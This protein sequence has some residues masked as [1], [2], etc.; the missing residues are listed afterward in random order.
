MPFFNLPPS[1]PA[2]CTGRPVAIGQWV[3]PRTGETVRFNDF[4]NCDG[5]RK[6]RRFAAILA[7]QKA[8]IRLERKTIAAILKPLETPIQKEMDRLRWN[9]PKR[10]ELR[11]KLAEIRK[12]VR[13]MAS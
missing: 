13:E 5:I 12:S 3:D 10:Q 1:S 8:A 7:E 9:D 4:G 2:K 6:V 11:E